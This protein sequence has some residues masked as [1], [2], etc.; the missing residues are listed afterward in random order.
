MEKDKV[1]WT[2]IGDETLLFPILPNDK[3]GKL[4]SLEPQRIRTFH[5][6]MI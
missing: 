1:A 4:L 3:T 5:I 6:K 2:G